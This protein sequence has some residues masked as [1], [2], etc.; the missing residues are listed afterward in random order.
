MV[1]K[2]A[3]V[4]VLDLDL[5]EETKRRLLLLVDD[6]PVV[7]VKACNSLRVKVSWQS[8]RVE[9]TSSA[10]ALP[11]PLAL[12]LLLLLLGLASLLSLPLI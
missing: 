3:S 5:E 10:T 7:A 1:L 2:S 6:L 4:E 11:P 9:L 8:V 12:L